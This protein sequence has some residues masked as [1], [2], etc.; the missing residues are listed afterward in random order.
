M[1]GSALITDFVGKLEDMETDWDF[2][3]Q[4]FNLPAIPHRNATPNTMNEMSN[5]NKQLIQQRYHQDFTNFYSD[6]Y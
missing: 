2:L 1:N 5:R 6:Q 4:R 3:S